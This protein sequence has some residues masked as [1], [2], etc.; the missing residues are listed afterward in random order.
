MFG[1]IDGNNFYASCERIFRPDLRNKPVIVLSN[2]DGCA[3]ARSN[4]AKALGIKM[5]APAF[6][7]EDIINKNNVA[8]FSANFV[9]YGDISNRI[10]NICRR[11]C[12][13]IEVYSIDESFLDF[14]GYDYIN[15]QKHCE[16]LR[17]YVYRGLDIPTSV[18]IAPTKTLAKVAN[19]IAKKFPS[20]TNSVY[21]ID[22]PEKIEKALKWFPLE[23]VWGIGRR[24]FE[25]FSKLGLKK[26][27]DFVQ[28]PEQYVHKE[29]GIYGLRMHKELLGNS[30]YDLTIPKPKKGIAVTRTFEKRID[31]L[32]DLRERVSTY[33][34]KC[35]EKLRKQNSC[36]YYVTV[37]IMTDR[38]K[39]DLKQYSKS[40]TITLVNPSSSAIEIAKAAVRGL[41][42]IYLPFFQYKKAGVMVS[43]FVPDN[44]RMTSL[45]D[46]D[47]HEKHKPIMLVIDRMNKRLGCDKIKLA[48]MDIQR[49]WK[50]NQKNLSPKRST[51]F[52]QILTVKA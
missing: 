34:Y 9:L 26:A 43:E 39:P 6:Q 2:N 42:L 23:D 47:L 10:V 19:K 4:E 14:R 21:I 7:I 37:F 50:M 29:M 22:T 25:R 46:E 5:G 1:L 49:T 12:Q 28:L 27:W 24:Y 3:I 44:E 33:A 31:L 52:N 30:Q 32:E 15:L 13:D 20:E 45:F 35:S 18:G 17:E 8:V 16:E 38:F 40:I 36:C 48:S 11:Y 41:E 51:D